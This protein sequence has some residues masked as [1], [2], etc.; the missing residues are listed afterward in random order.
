M[1]QVDFATWLSAGSYGGLIVS[2]LAAGVIAIFA[3]RL[4]RGTPRQL[5]RAELVC[6]FACCLSFAPI[7]WEQTRFGLFGPT[8]APAEVGLWLAWAATFAW[9]VPLSTV[10]GYLLLAAPQPATGRVAV[11]SAM[12]APLRFLNCEPHP[13]SLRDPGRSVEPFG[14]GRPW[15]HLIP[16]DAEMSARPIPLTRAVT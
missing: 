13:P 10:T 4:R 1:D 9:A 7:W 11:P 8:L 14:P 5:A 2:L 16:V 15:G 6:L 3:L 12:R